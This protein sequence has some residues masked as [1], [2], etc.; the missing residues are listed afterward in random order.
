MMKE[1]CS[2]NFGRTLWHAL[3][4]T[5]VVIV[6]WISSLELHL[7]MRSRMCRCPSCLKAAFT[8]KLIKD[9]FIAAVTTGG[10]R[11]VKPTCTH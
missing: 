9:M 10:F 2:S 4:I 5:R 7:T 3:T 6:Q 11:C 1:T 8:G